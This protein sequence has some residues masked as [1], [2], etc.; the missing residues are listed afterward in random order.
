MWKIKDVVINSVTVRISDVKIITN[1]K[2]MYEENFISYNYRMH[3][4]QLLLGFNLKIY[5]RLDYD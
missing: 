1:R 4:C 5:A 2:E 3:V